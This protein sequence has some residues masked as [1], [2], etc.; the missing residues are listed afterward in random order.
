MSV[1]LKRSHIFEVMKR[2]FDLS[3]RTHGPGPVQVLEAPAIVDF[4]AIEDVSPFGPSSPLSR[5][6]DFSF[7]I[8]LYRFNPINLNIK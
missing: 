4:F 8:N 7:V 1:S 2:M 3:E 5:S 6:Y